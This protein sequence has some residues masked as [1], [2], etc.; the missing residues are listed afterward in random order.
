MPAPDWLSSSETQYPEPGPP[1]VEV[2]AVE[3]GPVVDVG[4]VVVTATKTEK[5]IDEVASS[6]SVVE[7]SEIDKAAVTTLD[8]VF[9]YT[10][11]IQIIR[12]EGMA[13]VHN[14]MSVRGMGGKRNLIYV[15]G[16]NM[17]ESYRG[18]TNLTFLPT[19]NLEK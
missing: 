3:V 5:G 1:D 18:T 12:G 6:V 16:V 2:E 19:E 4:E 9:E 7:G 13:T 17:V 8:Q 10:P 11:D 15:D 14:F